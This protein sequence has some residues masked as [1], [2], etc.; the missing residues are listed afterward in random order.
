MC[1]LVQLFASERRF[2]AITV[3]SLVGFAIK[4]TANI[5]LV[6]FYGTQGVLLATGAGAAGVLACYLFWTRFAPPYADTGKA[7]Q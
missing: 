3:I 1:V 4:V 6:R 2:K 7:M 5:I